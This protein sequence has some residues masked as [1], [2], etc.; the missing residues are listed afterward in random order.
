MK[1]RF[2][3]LGRKLS[4]SLSPQI[5]ALFGDYS[6]E[7]FERE[8]EELDALFADTSLNGFNVTIPYKVEALK[9][10]DTLSDTAKRIGAVN[11][12]I[13]REDGTLFGDNTDAFGFSYMA[14]QNGVR[15]A[16][17]KVLV[18][19]SGG[20]SKTVQ[21]VAADE[22]AREVIVISRSAEN[23]Y[24]NLPRHADADVIVNT[25]PVGM[26]PNNLDSPV[27]LTLFRNAPAVLDLIYNPRR[28]ALLLQAQELG[29]RCGNGM[30][31]LVAQGKR[32]ADLFFGK[33]FDDGL[34][35]RVTNQMLRQQTNIVLIGMP[36]C[37]K[38]TVALRLS[39]A[40]SR[41]LFDT[42]AQI[43]SK[44]RTISQI[45][46]E[47][48]EAAFRDLETKACEEV[49]KSLG[50]V[51]ATG[52]GAVLRQRN[53]DALR[54][55]GTIVY[56]RRPLSDL[57]RDGRPLSKD[58]E[59]LETMYNQRKAIYE[60]IADFTVDVDSDAKITTERV[61]VCISSSSTDPT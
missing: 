26:Y 5:H 52:G 6:Y 39:Q 1:Q 42:D 25:T 50:G 33:A 22:G 13:R 54:Q 43:A 9:R 20:A 47:S 24:Q 61:M 23:N 37:G 60:S 57:A 32:S 29:L 31:M 56:L 4:H 46:A 17:K 51:I 21:T 27:D 11:T 3:L 10:C 7:L 8:P 41:P 19:G 40:L 14:A 59:A 36:G 12:V 38:S 15:F 58:S 49:G 2:G 45:F 53:C 35:G 30:T 18:L 55:N 34:I 28:T 48:G 16:G 44:G